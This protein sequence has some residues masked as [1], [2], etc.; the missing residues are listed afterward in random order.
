[1]S[2][3]GGYDIMFALITKNHKAIQAV[4]HSIEAKFS[5]F[6]KET[7]V[8]HNT[9]MCS[10]PHA[11]LYGDEFGNDF[12]DCYEVH[13]DEK[14]SLSKNE[15]AILNYF[16]KNPRAQVKD[17]VENT[18]LSRDTVRRTLGRLAERKILLRCKAHI[19]IFELGYQWNMLL[20]LGH[21]QR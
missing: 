18:T 3:H 4:L 19:N 8:L 15:Y 10:F 7:D 9:S 16:K 20:S 14:S 11:Y 12:E 6:I 13:S 2:L 5:E 1:M 17:V 21:L